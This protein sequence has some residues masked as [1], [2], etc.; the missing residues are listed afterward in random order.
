MIAQFLSDLWK[1]TAPAMGNHLWQSTVFAAVAGLLTLVLRKNHASARYWLWMA[2]SIKFLLPFSL[3][4]TLGNYISP[5][6]AVARSTG[7]FYLVMDTVSQPFSRG[8]AP[9]ATHTSVMA[10]LM[11][12]LPAIL[13]AIWLCGFLAVLFIWLMRW[14]RISLAMR[15]AVPVQEGREV[16]ALRRLEVAGGIRKRILLL[17]S[18]STLEPG[19]FGIARPVLVWP[20]GISDRLEDAHLEAI[21]AHEVWH[22]RRHDN[23][24]AV[25]HMLV[26]AIFWF[27]PLV[28]WLGARLIDERER[29]CDEQVLQLGNHPQVY[30]ESILKICEF[31]VG[32][33]LAC[34]AGVTGADLK[35]RIVNIMNERITR[36][37]DLTRKLLLSAA[38]AI[39]LFTP[40]IVG[41]MKPVQSHAQTPAQSD[42]SPYPRLRKCFHQAR[43]LHPAW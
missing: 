1:S 37:L 18:R 33:P 11:Q 22:V 35:Q 30:A 4:V 32:S 34:V 38:A 3:L 17:L 29:A 14:Q 36:K 10:E 9:V 21:L 23:L 27:H 24:A 8:A 41:L 25:I 12:M 40:L 26:E 43:C 6:Q 19:I 28:W 16:A 2:A 13:A 5:R 7:D 15:S 31:C 20:E 42:G 39:A